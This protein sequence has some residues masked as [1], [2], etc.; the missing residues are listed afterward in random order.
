MLNSFI[1]KCGSPTGCSRSI[2]GNFEKVLEQLF[3]R[4][5]PRIYL[6]NSEPTLLRA[7][8]YYASQTFF[9]AGHK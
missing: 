8:T 1:E 9:P 2:L 7:I 4:P 5:T 3:D 6:C